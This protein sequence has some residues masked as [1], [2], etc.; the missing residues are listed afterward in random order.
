MGVNQKQ[1]PSLFEEG[2][3][4]IRRLLAGET[5]SSEGRYRIHEARIAPIPPE[6]VEVW[7]GGSAEPSVDRAA[8]LGDAYLG[9]PELTPEQA[10]R[11]IDFYR[12]RCAAYGR[13][14]SAIGLRRDVYV[15]ATPEEARAVVGPLIE[16]GYRGIDP[17]ALAYGS[18]DEVTEQLRA[19]EDMGYTDILIRHITNDQAQVLGS[20]ARSGRVRELMAG[21]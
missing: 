20:I 1:R 2:L 16:R 15:G 5:V 17:S 7:I 6:P 3:D 21:R 12:E 13:Q 19:Y 8:R 4:I 14:P 10:K 11:W 18:A 9:G